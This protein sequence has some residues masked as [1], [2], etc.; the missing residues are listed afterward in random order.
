MKKLTVL[1]LSAVLA[2]SF[3]ACAPDK[4]GIVGKENNKSGDGYV[5]TDE[6]L[7]AVLPE[8]KSAL[9]FLRTATIWLSMESTTD[10]LW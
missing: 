1:L 7:T 5:M 2:L 3:C 10:I 9:G 6:K 8:I 4:S